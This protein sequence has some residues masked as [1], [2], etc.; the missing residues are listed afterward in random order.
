LPDNRLPVARSEVPRD[1]L[2]VEFVNTST[3]SPLEVMRTT[4]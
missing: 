3:G 1:A 2:A 4:R